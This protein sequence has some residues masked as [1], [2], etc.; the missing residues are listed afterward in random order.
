MNTFVRRCPG[1]KKDAS[2]VVDD[3]GVKAFR[4]GALVQDAFP[5]LTADQ[6][7][8]IIS[9]YHGPCFDVLFPSEEEPKD[10]SPA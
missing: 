2:V 5:G 7:E 4:N 9:G 3:A 1:C 10:K 6:R 8:Q